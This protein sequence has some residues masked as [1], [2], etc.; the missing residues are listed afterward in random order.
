M[1]I[2]MKHFLLFI[3]LVIFSINVFSQTPYERGKSHIKKFEYTKAW[4]EFN[5][6][7]TAPSF[8]DF[9]DLKRIA[10]NWIAAENYYKDPD[11]TYWEN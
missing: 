6:Y 2:D 4:S 9:N 8:D 1:Q 7:R 3:F 11:K 10:E 5:V